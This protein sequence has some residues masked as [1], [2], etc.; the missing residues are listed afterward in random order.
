M[1]RFF[2]LILALFV[3]VGFSGHAEGIDLDSMS[4]FELFELQFE[5]QEKLYSIDP[6]SGFI[7][8]PGS[9]VV[10]RDLKAGTYVFK[11]VEHLESKIN[12]A[13]ISFYKSEKDFENFEDV[14]LA[15]SSFFPGQDDV[16]QYNLKDGEVIKLQY[17]IFQY[18]KR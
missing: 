8:F 7:L 6:A 18:I 4:T 2:I 11:V 3:F 9:Y 12:R 5:I 10:G 16:A 17:G 14:G 15:S 13:Y 1:R